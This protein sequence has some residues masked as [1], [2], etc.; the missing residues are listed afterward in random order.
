MSPCHPVTVS[1]CR[2]TT[3]IRA[4]ALGL[5]CLAT[6]LC[7]AVRADSP[8]AVTAEEVQ[9]LKAKY[10]AERAEA[11]KAGTAK[12]FSP[13]LFKQVDL[14]AKKGEAE[15]AAGRLAQARE[16]FRE[17]RWYFPVQSLDF[18]C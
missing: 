6:T 17:A 11:D 13:E 5:F 2:P 14:L 3:F 4:L 16:A 8:K 18:F 12:K 15:L 1:P 10:Q 9:A 7:L